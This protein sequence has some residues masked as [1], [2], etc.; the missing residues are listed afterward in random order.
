MDDEA[1]HLTPGEVRR[2]IGRL[3]GPDV[4]RLA[5]LA[6]IWAKGLRRYDRDDLLNG[7]LARVLSGRRPWPREVPVPAF[8]SEGASP[9]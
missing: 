1:T 5:A 6:G 4:L 7:A 9:T 8:V 2:I 3:R